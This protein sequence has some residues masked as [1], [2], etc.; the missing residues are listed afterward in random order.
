MDNIILNLK[1]KRIPE[2][3]I[4]KVNVDVPRPEQLRNISNSARITHTFSYVNC[5]GYDV[6]MV[7]RSGVSHVVRNDDVL[8][9]GGKSLFYVHKNYYVRDSSTITNSDRRNLTNLFGCTL[10][11]AKAIEAAMDDMRYFVGKNP[12]GGYNINILYSIDGKFLASRKTGAYYR[13]FDLCLAV[14]DRGTF[15]DIIHPS[16][17]AALSSFMSEFKIRVDGE[18]D[19]GLP[20]DFGFPEYNPMGLI[21]VHNKSID[22]PERFIRI[23]NEI[24]RV[25]VAMDKRLKSGVYYVPPEQNCDHVNEIYPAPA[26]V[27]YTLEEADKHFALFKSYDHAFTYDPAKVLEFNK[28]MDV[29]RKEGELKDKK[30]NELETKLS[31]LKAKYTLDMATAKK[32]ALAKDN[33]Y[34]ELKANLHNT[35]QELDKTKKSSNEVFEYFKY[36]VMVTSGLVTLWKTITA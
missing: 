7:D 34:I 31:E 19:R 3:Y 23:G 33:A 18:N 36:F 27:Y 21:I 20:E 12:I 1:D 29:E 13:E 25:K 6:K 16:S 32:E 26:P 4:N 14:G 5:T 30:I 11:E 22:I 10:V 17:A 15:P 2:Y 9:L 24:L 8:S 35:K 28:L